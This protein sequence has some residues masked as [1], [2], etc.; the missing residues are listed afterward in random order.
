MIRATL[1]HGPVE[2]AAFALAI[3]LYLK[4]RHHALALRQIAAT[5]AV[6]LGLLACAALLEA[7]VT[8]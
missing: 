5:A 8:V 1:P 2:L 6:S 3:A 7:L 4:G